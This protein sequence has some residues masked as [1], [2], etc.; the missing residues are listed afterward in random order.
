VNGYQWALSNLRSV[1]AAALCD[2]MGLGKTIQT[3]AVILALKEADYLEESPALVVCPTSL[4]S[5]W[6]REL[7][8]FA[9]SLWVLT[10][11]G[12]NRAL[13]FKAA[14]G[15]KRKKTSGPD[16]ILM[17]Y[18]TVR[19]D[20]ATLNKA[21]YALLIID[22]AQAIKNHKSAVSKAVKKIGAQA[23]FRLALTGTV[24]ENRLAELHSCFDF[25]LPGYLGTLKEFT[26]R[27]AKPIEN[28]RDQE[29]LELLKRMTS[30]FML[31]REKTDPAVISDLPEK[32]ESKL[33]VQ[34]SQEQVALYESVRASVFE[35]MA[36]EKDAPAGSVMRRSVLVL[37]LLS[38][39]KQI[40]NHPACYGD[41][42]GDV[43]P[44]RSQK[45]LDLLELLGPIVESGEKVLVFSQYVKTIRI[46]EKQ[47]ASNFG[48]RPLVFEGS[49]SQDQ[50]GAIIHQFDR[51][52][53]RQVLLLSLKAGGVGLNL[54]S[55][56]H[57]TMIAVVCLAH[58]VE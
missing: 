25:C 54:T 14:V 36:Q 27:F 49:L 7:T 11:S 29:T 41:R 13:T 58:V 4:L 55:A 6:R 52:P 8:K 44:E 32:I 16:V 30:C 39:L 35:V 22:E 56:N 47:I 37:K 23:S 50:R 40:C 42:P 48:I 5:N 34:L 43:S 46:L 10:C 53:A 21:C 24:V 28:E 12:P 51:N 2:D 18:G 33:Y 19:Q 26:N 3:I 1:G 57:G 9:P 45:C 15:E 20:V 31:R 38:D 17:S